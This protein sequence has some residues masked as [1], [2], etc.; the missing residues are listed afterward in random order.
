MRTSVRRFVVA[1]LIAGALPLAASVPSIC[2]VVYVDCDNVSG[3]EDGTPEHPFRL[4][5]SGMAAAT[6]GDT[7]L[8]MPGTYSLPVDMKDGVCL[9]GAEGPDSTVIHTVGSMAAVYFESCGPATTLSGFTIF[10]AGIVWD[11][12]V[13]IW[14]E[15]SSPDIVG[16]VTLPPE[17]QIYCTTGS[18]P[19]VCQNTV[20][21]PGVAFAR[22]SGG[23]VSGNLIEG[24]VGI[25]AI[26]VPCLPLLVEDNEICGDSRP[27]DD[28]GIRVEWVTSGD[29]QIVNNTIRDKEVGALLC[30]GEL[31][32]NRFLNNDLNVKVKQYCET[33]REIMAEMNWWGTTDPGEVAAKILDCVDDPAIPGCVDYEPWCMDPGCTQSP[34]EARSWGSIKS[35]Y[36]PGQ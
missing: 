26:S 1:F 21:S 18:N 36:A 17:G 27:W 24:C 29:I 35:L 10:R 2:A 19:K 32:G 8:V 15:G 3:Q 23:V 16:N 22:G 13:A 25:E 9:L 6:F 34:V 28:A 33:R 31:R 5:S 7:V 14:C 20:G 12:A 4:I 11:W 30:F